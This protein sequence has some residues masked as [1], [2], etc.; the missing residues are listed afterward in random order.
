MKDLLKEDTAYIYYMSKAKVQ[1]VSIM[2]NKG[3]YFFYYSLC[4]MK[5]INS[6]YHI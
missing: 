4:E 1:M 5:N 6:F 3:H 2:E